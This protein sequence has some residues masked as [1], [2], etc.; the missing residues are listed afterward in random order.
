MRKL[1]SRRKNWAFDNKVNECKFYCLSSFGRAPPTLWKN[2]LFAVI[3][4]Y[5][6]F[7]AAPGGNGSLRAWSIHRHHE[8]GIFASVPVVFLVYQGVFL[9][10]ISI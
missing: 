7:P 2:G 6:L 1:E 8:N 10:L 9:S 3:L 4:K 5:L